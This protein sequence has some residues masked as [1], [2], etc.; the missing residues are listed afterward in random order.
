MD[1]PPQDETLPWWLA[2]MKRVDHDG[3]GHGVRVI[4][5]AVMATSPED[6]LDEILKNYPEDSEL[7]WAEVEEQPFGWTPFSATRPYRTGMVWD[8]KPH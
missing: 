8:A 3:V 2:H 7:D 5:A 1:P 4:I 6:A